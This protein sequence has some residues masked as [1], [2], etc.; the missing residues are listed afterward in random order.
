MVRPRN[1]GGH[2]ILAACLHGKRAIDGGFII[3]S[4]PLLRLVVS[5]PLASGAG[6][7]FASG[8]FVQIANLDT[9]PHVAAA[10]SVCAVT[11]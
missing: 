6:R 7:A 2:G 8:W 5:A 3:A 9:R 11:T 10:E 1:C 4:S